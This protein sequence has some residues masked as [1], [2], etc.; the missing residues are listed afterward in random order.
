MKSA[1][2]GFGE[3]F[4]SSKLF[5]ACHDTLLVWRRAI[6]ADQWGL[7]HQ[8]R[9]LLIR[10]LRNKRL[11]QSNMKLQGRQRDSSEISTQKSF[12]NAAG[13]LNTSLLNE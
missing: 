3:Q 6:A 4:N 12:G 13:G 8:E 7:L 5:V 10:V 9:T 11:W 1:M 2:P